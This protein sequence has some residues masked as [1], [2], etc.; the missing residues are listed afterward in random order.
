MNTN[1]L[2]AAG[3]V[4]VSK[5]KFEKVCP[6]KTHKAAVENGVALAN[7]TRLSNDELK[8]NKTER[9]YLC[10]LRLTHYWVGIQSITLKLAHDCRYSPDFWT[11]EP[12]DRLVAYEVKGF[13]RDDARVKLS[14]AARLF[15]MFTF[16]LVRR[17]KDGGWDIEKVKA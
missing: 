17:A 15:P 9:D 11:Q 8:L 1:Q 12:N 16:L 13:M 2:K 14:V 5:G 3:F 10:Y 6:A 7:L 4:E